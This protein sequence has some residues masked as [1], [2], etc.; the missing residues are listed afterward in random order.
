[1][2]RVPKMLGAGVRAAVLLACAGAVVVAQDEKV[3]TPEDLDRVMKK[4]QPAMQATQKAISAGAFEDARAQVAT[5]RKTIVDSQQ[6]WIEKKRDDALKMNQ[7]TVAKIDALEKALSAPSVEAPA[8]MAALKEV[9][10]TCR[11]C[12]QK[13]RATDAESNYIIKPGSLD[14]Q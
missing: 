2:G 13:Y 4:S 1:M 5:L 12:H 10:M 9:G 6:F 3:T 14:G 11:T 7:E 8:A